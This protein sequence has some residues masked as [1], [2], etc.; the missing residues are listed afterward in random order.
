MVYACVFVCHLCVCLHACMHYTHPGPRAGL[1]CHGENKIQNAELQGNPW[2]AGEPCMG[3]W[4]MLSAGQWD[5][6][7]AGAVAK[8]S[9]LEQTQL[10]FLSLSPLSLHLPVSF[11]LV[12]LLSPAARSAFAL[13]DSFSPSFL[14]PHCSPPRIFF[15][16][17]TRAKGERAHVEKFTEYFMQLVVWGWGNI[18]GSPA[19]RVMCVCF[20]ACM[21][22]YTFMPVYLFCCVCFLSTC[23]VL[24]FCVR[25]I[26]LVCMCFCFC[27]FLYL[28]LCAWA[29]MCTYPQSLCLPGLLGVWRGS[30]FL[31]VQCLWVHVGEL[32]R[33]LELSSWSGVCLNVSQAALGTRLASRSA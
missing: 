21:E 3:L 4:C 17:S 15:C 5:A 27:S 6:G 7:W 33:D 28:S 31:C 32:S 8:G 2:L 9:S 23:I 22:V 29:L 1:C 30:M 25:V 18:Q 11:W 13:I 19:H 24:G 12:C 10:G 14:S 16:T 26:I 20:S